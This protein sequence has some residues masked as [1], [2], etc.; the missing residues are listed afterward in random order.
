MTF[1]GDLSTSRENSD[2]ADINRFEREIRLLAG[3]AHDLLLTEPGESEMKLTAIAGICGEW[4]GLLAK[5][6]REREDFAE[7]PREHVPG[8]DMAFAEGFNQ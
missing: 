5:R 2:L 6:Q 7:S 1:R 3:E 4:K 8:P